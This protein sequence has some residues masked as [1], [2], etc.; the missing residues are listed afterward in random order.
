MRNSKRL[1]P[2]FTFEPARIGPA[3]EE[4]LKKA[5]GKYDRTVVVY[6]HCG[7]FDLDDILK[8]TGQCARWVRTAMKCS[9]AKSF[10]R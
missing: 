2:S 1:T 7:A 8:N 6:G 10:P 9:A 3:V 5:Q 4:R